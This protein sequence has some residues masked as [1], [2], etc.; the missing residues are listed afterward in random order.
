M[1]VP[2]GSILIIIA[3]HLLTIPKYLRVFINFVV[4]VKAP[5]NELNRVATDP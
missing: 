5:Q 1:K 2:S 3:V 4:V